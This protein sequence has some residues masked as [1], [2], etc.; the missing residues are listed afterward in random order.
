MKP[1]IYI[2]HKPFPET[3]A[4]LQ[5]YGRVI[6][7]DSEQ[8][9]PPEKIHTAR[10]A[11]DAIMVFMPDSL[12][13]ADVAGLPYLKIV[14]GALKGHDNFDVDALAERGIW[15]SNVPDLLT[16]P[17][18]EL[19]VGLL[20]G[21][22]RHLLPSDTFVREGR[23]SGW[24]PRFYGRGLAGSTVGIIGMG[25]VGRALAERLEP[26]GM[27][28]V[29]FERKPQSADFSQG[30]KASCLPLDRVIAESDFLFPLT[31]LYRET[32]H[33]IG[34]AELAGMKPG[35]LLINIG[36]GGLVDETAIADALESGH[37]AG[38][39]ADV[40][41]MEDWL[42]KARPRTINPRLLAMRSKTLFTPHTGSAVTEVRMA[43]E[44]TAALNIIDV[45]SGKPPRNAVR[46]IEKSLL[47]A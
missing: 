20:I 32:H 46:N 31:H 25:A 19:G 34:A 47:Q 38:Y 4:L 37:L 22:A 30:T 9:W 10:E 14:A 15:F 1:Q 21:L 23:F 42:I 43:I 5:P 11:A 17:T 8:S 28:I 12:G 41:E 6:W 18:A 39:A 26:F 40:F 29:Y 36:R 2:T 3:L 16:V 24:V 7:N 13:A 45:L 35:A 44:R 33:L 27:R